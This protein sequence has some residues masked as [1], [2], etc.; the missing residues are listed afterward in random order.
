[1]SEKQKRPKRRKRRRKSDAEK[2]VDEVTGFIED[3]P[4]TSAVAA[5][6]AGAV[7]TSVFK[8]FITDNKAAGEAPEPD[9]AD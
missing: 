9:E 4:V 6:A 5:L 1:M 7:A 8:M 2:T 3:N